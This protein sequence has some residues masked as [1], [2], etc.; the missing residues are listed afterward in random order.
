[1]KTVVLAYHN[2]GL[3]GLAALL[4]HGFDIAAVFTHEDD[5][6]EN[7]WFGSVKEWALQHNIPF[8]TPENINAPE[9]IAKITGWQP[10]MI[11]PFITAKWSVRRFWTFPKAAL[12]TYTGRCCRLTAGG[13]RSTG[14][15]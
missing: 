11:F 3:A 7:C 14:C 9:W 15:W 4:K 8:Y 5:P 1:L 6:G 12:L 2:M 13:A 10:D